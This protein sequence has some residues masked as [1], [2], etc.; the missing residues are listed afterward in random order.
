MDQI[1]ISDKKRHLNP[2]GKIY[3]GHCGSQDTLIIGIF[4][5]G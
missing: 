5:K 1:K 4:L 2:K 3:L